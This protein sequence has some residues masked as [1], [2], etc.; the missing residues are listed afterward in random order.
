MPSGLSP[1][2]SRLHLDEAALWAALNG[3][4]HTEI[5][6]WDHLAASPKALKSPDNGLQA[7]CLAHIAAVCHGS[8]PS[9]R[10]STFFTP[11]AHFGLWSS[12]ANYAHALPRLSLP[13][14]GQLPTPGLLAASSSHL[15]ISACRSSALNSL[16]MT[17]L[18]KASG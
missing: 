3:Q 5:I 13:R 9:P 4:G 2:G 11:M 12:Y 17:F 15:K 6:A 1:C 16:V 8:K 7:R 18:L 10:P 14:R